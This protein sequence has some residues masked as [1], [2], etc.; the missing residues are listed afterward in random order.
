MR[1][2][3]A[4]CAKAKP[5]L[6]VARMATRSLVKERRLVYSLRPRMPTP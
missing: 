1:T 2:M 4:G 6:I 5:T 3:L